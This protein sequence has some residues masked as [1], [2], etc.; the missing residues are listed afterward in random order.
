M[1]FSSPV[2]CWE[3]RDVEVSDEGAAPSYLIALAIGHYSFLEHGA[4]NRQ[5]QKFHYLD[6]AHTMD[7]ARIEEILPWMEGELGLDASMDGALQEVPVRN[8]KHGAMENTGCVLLGDFFLQDARSPFLDRSFWRSRP[9]NWR[10]T[11]S[12]FRDGQ[13]HSCPLVP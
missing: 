8:F 7:H 12:E 10:I 5:L 1:A 4:G 9:T 11:G 3:K 2:R 13:G 6:Q